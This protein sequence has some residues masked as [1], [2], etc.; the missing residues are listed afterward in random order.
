[1]HEPDDPNTEKRLTSGRALIDRFNYLV[2]HLLPNLTLAQTRAIL[3]YLRHADSNGIAFP[4]IK[5]ISQKMGLGRNSKSDDPEKRDRA[6]ERKIKQVHQDIIRMGFLKCHEP[7]RR[8]QPAKRQ[9][10]IPPNRVPEQDTES[11]L[12]GV[13]NLG[14][15]GCPIRGQNG[16]PIRASAHNNDEGHI[17]GRNNN[18]RKSVGVVG[19]EDH[20]KSQTD[21]AREDALAALIRHGITTGY[22]LDEVP[23]LTAGIIDRLGKELSGKA[24]AGVLVKMIRERGPEMVKK[25]KEKRAAELDA[26]KRYQDTLKLIDDATILDIATVYIEA[27]RRPYSDSP[28]ALPPIEQIKAS[29]DFAA[30]VKAIAKSPDGSEAAIKRCRE[31]AITIHDLNAKRSDLRNRAREKAD[32]MGTEELLRRARRMSLLRNVDTEPEVFRKNPVLLI[33]IEKEIREHECIEPLLKSTLPLNPPYLPA[34]PPPPP[35]FYT[36]R[37]GEYPTDIPTEVRRL[38]NEEEEEPAAAWKD[39]PYC[40]DARG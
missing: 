23:G 3:I 1:M 9:L 15:K 21:Y 7:G 26:E 13:P 30:T 40:P 32:A 25:E 4:G 34:G 22:L 19:S 18:N 38:G 31:I 12:N 27:N 29:P 28:I 8:G 6:V 39:T 14:A 11:K 33:E 24:G 36:C 5:T 37:R 2:D 35:K 17:K 20:K 16:C 10:F